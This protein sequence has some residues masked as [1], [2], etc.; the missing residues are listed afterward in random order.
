MVLETRTSAPPVEPA[1][2]VHGAAPFPRRL[3][4]LELFAGPGGLA[5]GTHKAGFRHLALIEFEATA[6][7]TLRANCAGPLEMDPLLV[8]HADARDVDY[9][10]FAG[11]VDLLTAGPPCQP[12]SAGGHGLGTDDA[13][14]MFPVLLDAVGTIRPRA[15]LI[16][17]VRGLT[18]EKFQDY[19]SYIQERLKFP[20]LRQHDGEDWVDHYRRLRVVSDT[21]FEDDEQYV[22]KAQIVDAANHGIPQHRHRVFIVAIRRDL[23]LEPLAVP[24]THSREALL[25]DQ[26]VTGAYWT[27]HNIAPPP[28]PEPTPTHGWR[29][30]FFPLDECEPWATVRD[31]IGTLPPPVNRGET[32]LLANHVQHPGARPYKGHTGSTLDAPAKALKSGGH[33]TPGGENTLRMEDGTIRYLTVREA[34]CLQTFP[35]TWAFSGAWGACIKQ[36]G[37]A[38]PVELARL[39]ASAIHERLSAATPA[40]VTARERV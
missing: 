20:L 33:G 21:A 15:L 31:A 13:R 10:P 39:F 9:T 17:N 40:A 7:R 5:L 4:C 24:V 3:T 23:G 11:V 27:R 30:S 14:N 38:V 34:A 36:L 6:A 29:T 2:L 32:E 26:W 35:D 19:F 12:F 1:G 25:R 37:N 28:V 16:E 22:V 8:R 18:R